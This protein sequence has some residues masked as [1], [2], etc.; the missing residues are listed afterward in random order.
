[1]R[2]LE[3]KMFKNAKGSIEYITTILNSEIDHYNNVEVISIE[4]QFNGG[5]EVLYRTFKNA[6]IAQ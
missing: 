3:H 5:Y 4:K 2:E 6:R 1:M